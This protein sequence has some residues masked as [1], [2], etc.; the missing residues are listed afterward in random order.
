MFN[1]KQLSRR[2]DVFVKAVVVGVVIWLGPKAQAFLSN[3][4]SGWMTAAEY[5]AARQAN[6]YLS[7]FRPWFDPQ[8]LLDFQPWPAP[9]KPEI[10]TPAEVAQYGFNIWQRIAISVVTKVIYHPVT[11]AYAGWSI[12]R[13]EWDVN[14]GY[15]NSWDR[16]L[17]GEYSSF[18][19]GWSFFNPSWDRQKNGETY[20]YLPNYPDPL[21]YCVDLTKDSYGEWWLMNWGNFTLPSFEIAVAWDVN[22]FPFGRHIW[23]AY[24]YGEVQS[25][26]SWRI[27]VARPGIAQ[28]IN[29]AW[30]DI[31]P[32]YEFRADPY[33]IWSYRRLA[34]N[35]DAL[36]YWVK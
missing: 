22:C 26:S 5:L 17:N 13:W 15:R 14:Y 1:Q 21:G 29:P 4:S 33:L 3:P 10:R 23:D 12:D 30:Q 9:V 28:C 24:S 6:P 34:A 31:P 8:P 20:Q 16:E 7:P 19:S 18:D 11:F 32:N 35:H 27:I 25:Y 36:P 2:F